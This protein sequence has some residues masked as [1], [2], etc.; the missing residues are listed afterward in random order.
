MNIERLSSGWLIF[1]MIKLSFLGDLMC[2][3]A[4][5]EASL[6]KFGKLDFNPQFE[7]CKRLYEE[8]DF[9]IGNLETPINPSRPT[10]QYDIRFNSA[11]EFLDAIQN[12]GVDFVSLANNHVLDQD[13]AGLDETIACLEEIGMQYSGAY[14]SE[15]DSDSIFLKEIKGVKFSIVCSTFSTNSQVNGIF[16]APNEQWRVDLLNKQKKM[17]QHW[18]PN[19]NAVLEDYIADEMS[20]AAATNSKNKPFQERLRDKMEKAKNMSDVL[21]A[22]PHVGGQYN[23]HPGNYAKWAM[24]FFKENGADV[25]VAGHPH[26]PQKCVREGD[27]FECYS[28]GNYACTPF[29]GWYLPNSFSEYGIV[30]HTYFEEE[31]K[32]LVKTTFSI[33]KSIVDEYGYTTIVPVVDLYQQASTV[34]KERL[35]IDCEEIISRL[36]GCN[37]NRN[38][39][40]EEI[41]L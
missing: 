10:S 25:I 36:R 8:S 29:V 3:K 28:L 12:A 31:S 39:I 23:P 41:D 33:V 5:N 22:M 13:V 37:D 18:E 4:Q 24:N 20:I 30:L 1:N 9:V 40:V 15:H 35:Q 17:L 38:E 7:F 34:E 19:P 16:L 26:V 14:K 11:K 27:V 2:L 32:K 21:I 6:K